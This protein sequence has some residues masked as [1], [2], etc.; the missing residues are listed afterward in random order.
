[1]EREEFLE[2]YAEAARDKADCVHDN[3][4]NHNVR[5]DLKHLK[6]IYDDSSFSSHEMPKYIIAANQEQ[7]TTLMK[8]LERNNEASQEIWDLIRMLATNQ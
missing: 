1:M 4:K 6:D 2:F 3:L 7:F 5:K 8:Q